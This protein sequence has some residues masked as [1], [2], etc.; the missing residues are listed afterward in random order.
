MNEKENLLKSL[1]EIMGNLTL[2][3]LKAI[4]RLTWS[5]VGS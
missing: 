4:H 2:D 3:E 5:C 1:N